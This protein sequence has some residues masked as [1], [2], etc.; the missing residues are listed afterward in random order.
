MA[1]VS[2]IEF[3]P[4]GGGSNL[5]NRLDTNSLSTLKIVYEVG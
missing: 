2:T 4:N 3:T 1:D 5:I